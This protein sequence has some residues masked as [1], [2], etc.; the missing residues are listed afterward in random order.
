[1]ID[2]KAAALARIAARKAQ[3]SSQRQFFEPPI[4]VAKPEFVPAPEILIPSDAPI[5]FDTFGMSPEEI[6]ETRQAFAAQ[7]VLEQEQIKNVHII[8][9]NPFQYLSGSLIDTVIETLKDESKTDE[10]FYK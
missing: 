10:E 6:E 7:K 5:D 1:M 2:E 8:E 3:G 4:Q 9:S